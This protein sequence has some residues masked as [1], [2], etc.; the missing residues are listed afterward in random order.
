MGI[1][2]RGIITVNASFRSWNDFVQDKEKNGL[3]DKK[4]QKSWEM[5]IQD[6]LG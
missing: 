2:L 4:T 6:K 1:K 3:H 5:G